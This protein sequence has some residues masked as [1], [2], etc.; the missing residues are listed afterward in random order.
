MKFP[1]EI[2]VDG[3]R[4]GQ[5]AATHVPCWAGHISV[6]FLLQDSAVALILL[7]SEPC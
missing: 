7:S 4:I 5:H 6:M 1:Q 3:H 2:L